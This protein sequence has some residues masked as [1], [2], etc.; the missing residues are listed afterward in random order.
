MVSM[1]AHQGE[2]IHHSLIRYDEKNKDE[3]AL[4]KDAVAQHKNLLTWTG[5]RERKSMDMDEAAKEWL[6][7]GATT[8]GLRAE[9]YVQ[10]MKQVSG[11]PRTVHREV[12]V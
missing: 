1:L 12:C 5:E 9:L 8:P 11:G 2:Q 4:A 7:A 6:R 3:H 10:L